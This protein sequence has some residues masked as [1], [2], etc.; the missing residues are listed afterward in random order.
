MSEANK[1]STKKDYSSLGIISIQ[2]LASSPD[3]I[4]KCYSIFEELFEILE[5]VG[6]THSHQAV[7]LSFDGEGRLKIE[8]LAGGPMKIMGYSAKQP[9]F[10]CWRPPFFKEDNK[11]LERMGELSGLLPSGARF[12]LPIPC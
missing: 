9:I 11:T 4:E 10:N 7:R 12:I 2:Y 1:K 5:V 3:E 6:H 8:W